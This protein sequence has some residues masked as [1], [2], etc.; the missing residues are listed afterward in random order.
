M[1]DMRAGRV[2]LLATL[3]SSLLFLLCA[4]STAADTGA[5][6]PAQP[7]VSLTALQFE[8]DSQAIDF[9][10]LWFFNELEKQ[11]GVH[12]DF[13]EV[14]QADWDSKLNLMFASGH[15][16][17]LIL[18]G[19]LDVEEYGVSQHLL[20]PLETLIPQYMPHYASRLNLDGAGDSIPSSDGHSYYV[21]FLISQG[22]NTNGHFFINKDW[23]TKLNLEVPTTV[24]E[25]TEV[26]RA[27]RDGD[28][29]GNGLRDEVPYEA[30]FNE[31]NAGLYN[32]FAFWGVPMNEYFICL[33]DDGTVYCP[34]LADGFRECAQWLHTLCEEK[35][36]DI[37]CIT[38]SVNLW[39]AKVNQG[40]AGFFTYWRLS[41]S[42]LK[43]EIADQFECVL[44]VSADGYRAK[45][46]RI[47]DTV[48]FGAALT[49]SNR[50][51]EDSLRWLDAQFDTETMMVSQNGPL[52][53]TLAVDDS[54]KYT[55]KYIP[56]DNELYSIVPVICGQFFAP[57]SYY[58]QVY[59]PASHRLEKQGYSEYYEE[60]GVMEQNSFQ[61]LTVVASKTSEESK[62]IQ[63]LKTELENEINSGLVSFI[64]QGVTDESWA[65]YR[66]SLLSAGVEEYVSLY[67][68]VYDR[69]R[70]GA[71]E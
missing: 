46:S 21:G 20:I 40:I 36:M 19:S 34:A 25:L 44:P 3:L 10:N 59:V 62:R 12:V 51:V 65:A 1:A 66:Q 14:K 43:P 50:H 45:V 67:Q 52:G 64:A 8:L 32:A 31:N 24:E 18:R 63:E 39:G 70:E 55:V 4:C 23:L 6:D 16:N 56:A 60:S 27:F 35:L 38:Q 15:Y 41:N 2:W 57:P 61:L 33:D 26:L 54:G 58:S 29:N 28:P 68:T 47:M 49:V 13:D 17:D 53:D 42:V 22:V 69:Y 30:I 7:T 71:H 48:E 5:A 9:S 37:E 11:T